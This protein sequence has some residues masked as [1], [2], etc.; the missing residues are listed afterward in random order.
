M[1]SKQ[2]SKG[3]LNM[4]SPQKVAEKRGLSVKHILGLPKGE[5]SEEQ[6]ETS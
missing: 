1:L 5:I 3:L 2:L 4:K 6:K